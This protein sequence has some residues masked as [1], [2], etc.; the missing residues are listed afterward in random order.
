MDW[1]ALLGGSGA[2]KPPPMSRTKSTAPSKTRRVQ[3][4]V[5]SVSALVVFKKVK[6]LRLTIRPPQGDIH[7]SAPIRMTLAP[8]RAFVEYRMDWIEQHQTEIR[9][10]TYP[11]PIQ[12]ESGDSILVWGQSYQLVV[13]EKRGRASVSLTDSELILT[14]RS[15][16]T[17]LHREKAVQKWLREVLSEAIE[18]LLQEWE[19]VMKVKSQSYSIRQMKTR[20]GSCNTRA[21]T[22]RFNTELVKK[23]IECLE[24][25]VVHELVHLLERSHNARFKAFMDQFLPQWRLI[26]KRLNQPLSDGTMGPE[27]G[28]RVD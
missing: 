14:I 28:G 8:I 19:P 1:N 9:S 13:V 26:Q 24:Y 12:Y 11:Q 3:I 18:S 2:K 10:R 16:A 23:P 6:N 20:W 21:H 25:V 5:G 27:S 15:T 22:I 4:Q 17:S 7:I